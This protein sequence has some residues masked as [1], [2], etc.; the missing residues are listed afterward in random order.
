MADR[1]YVGFDE[2]G[3]VHSWC[4][5]LSVSVVMFSLY[6]VRGLK[7]QRT[8]PI[9]RRER[10]YGFLDGQSGSCGLLWPRRALNYGPMFWYFVADFVPCLTKARKE[11]RHGLGLPAFLPASSSS[12]R[13]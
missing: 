6:R 13:L 2:E 11:T 10:V 8:R 7:E 4:R 5:G 9:P 1:V 3:P 12:W